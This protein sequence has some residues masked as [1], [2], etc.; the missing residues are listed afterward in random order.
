MSSKQR[1][2]SACPPTSFMITRPA[3][4]MIVRVVISSS[5]M[6]LSGPLLL[7]AY[8]LTSQNLQEM[9]HDIT[10]FSSSSDASHLSLSDSCEHFASSDKFPFLFLTCELDTGFTIHP[11][12]ECSPALPHVRVE[13]CQWQKLDTNRQLPLLAPVVG[14]ERVQTQRSFQLSSTCRL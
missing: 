11:S 8:E 9:H 2:M 4:T 13:S 1:V 14:R 6:L 7:G 12:V 10:M 5:S 3:S